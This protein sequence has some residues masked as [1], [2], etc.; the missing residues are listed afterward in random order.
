MGTPSTL[1]DKVW[2]RHVVEHGDGNDLLYVDL[3][4]VHEVTSP[5]AFDG[6][7]MY[8]RTV[9]RPDL[10][11]AT[12]DHNV[13]TTDIDRPVADPI[14]AKQLAAL[15]ANCAEFGIR[16]HPMGDPGQGI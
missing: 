10:T 11:V 16:L 15:S 6:L 2:A 3:H 14:S 5:Q 1:S 7:R 9:R 8:G 12:A 4:L 13:P